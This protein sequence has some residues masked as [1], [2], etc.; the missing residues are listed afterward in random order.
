MTYEFVS[1]NEYQPIREKLEKIIKQVQKD[2]KNNISFQFT[3]IGSGSKKLI[4]RVKKS[5]KGFDFDFNISIQK[6]KHEIDKA[7]DIREIFF[8]SIKNNIN[9]YGYRVQN[10]QTVITIKLIDTVNKKIEH[11]CDFGIVYDYENDGNMHQEIIVFDKNDN[12][13]KW[14]KR[15]Q[16]TNYNYKLQNI[17]SNQLWVELK[18]EYLKLKNKVANK[19]SFQLFLESISNVY[20]RYN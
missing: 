16:A 13:Y 4:T 19:K 10:S 1:K 7:K 8:N 9:K 20:N 6:V 5:N 18:E 12:Q 11:S 3:L 17:V 15:S 14:N 2:I